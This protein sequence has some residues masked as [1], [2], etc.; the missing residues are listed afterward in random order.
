MPT[1]ELPAAVQTTESKLRP[2]PRNPRQGNVEAIVASL[3]EHGQ[4]RALVVNSR[5]NQVL[6]GNH[7]FKALQQLDAET[8][9]VHFVDVDEDQ[10]GR[11]V[12]V[13]NRT[14]DLASYDDAALLELLESVPTLDG[15]GYADS[16]LDE[17]LSDDVLLPPDGEDDRVEQYGVIVLCHDESHQRDIYDKLRAQGFECKVVTT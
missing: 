3:R 6:A 10:A 17:L 16:D 7:T 9:L 2:Y 8:A 13:D 14:N 4:Y 11:M 5:T 1:T 12:L 15:T